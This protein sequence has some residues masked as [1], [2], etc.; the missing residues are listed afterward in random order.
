MNTFTDT[1]TGTP[2]HRAGF[3]NII[4]NPNVGKSTLM[5]QLVGEKISIMTSK[6]QTTRHRIKGI[7]NGD[8]YQIVYSDLPGVLEP[9][10]MMQKMMMRFVVDSLQ[11]A[12]II[13]YMVDC[14]EMKYHAELVEKI[15]SLARPIVL[16]I[17]KIDKYTEE[18]VAETEQFWKQLFP[19][20]DV[21]TVSAL[22]GVHIDELREKIIELLPLCPPYFPKDALTDRPMRFFV[23]ELIREQ[24]L[25]QY[26]KEIPYSVEVVVDSYKE[27]EDIIRI[28][29]ILYV[30]RDTQKAII[31][32]SKGAAI[33]KLGSDARL[34]IEDFLQKHVYLDLSVKVLKDWRNSELLMRRFGYDEGER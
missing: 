33:K 18:Q 14:G 13:L 34:S 29:A 31:I 28:G 12:D 20:A 32:G 7:V 1:L 16:T 5:N 21:L 9:A 22:K 17:N 2:D 6:A 11:D 15:K 24:I 30:E 19:D 10:Y 25:L 4:G 8:N 3:V 26:K 23:S 27:E